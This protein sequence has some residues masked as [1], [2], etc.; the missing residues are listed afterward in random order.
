[1]KYAPDAW[2][3]AQKIELQLAEVHCGGCQ[4][5]IGRIDVS[6]PQLLLQPLFVL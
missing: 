5:R 3:A 4:H 2:Q 1:M 6:T